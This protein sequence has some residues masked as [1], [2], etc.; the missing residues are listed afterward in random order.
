MN[1]DAN[2]TSRDANIDALI[3]H[4]IS[5][6]VDPDRHFLSGADTYARIYALANQ[7]QTVL[8]QQ[9]TTNRPVCMCSDN[10]ALVTAALLAAL[11][12]GPA[13]VLPYAYSKR[14]L[15]ETHQAIDFGV[16]LVD[17]ARPLPQGVT[18]I[19]L[20]TIEAAPATEM[21]K[22]PRTQNDEWIYLFTGGST[23]TPK[24]WT[25]TPCNL[26]A[27]A[28]NLVREFNVTDRD[29]ILATVPP[30]HIYG[31]LY[32]V[33]VPLLASAE[34]FPST[35]S[36][37]NEIIKLVAQADITIFVSIP[38]HYRALRDHRVERHNLRIAFSSAGALAPED[39]QAFFQSMAVSITEIYGST[40]TGGIAQRRRTAGQAALIPFSCIDWHIDDASLHVR[41]AFLS[42]ELETSDDGFFRTADRAQSDGSDG[43]SLLG[44][45]DGIV[46]VA[47][48]RV[49]LIKIQQI[50][51]QI[52]G[53]NDAY[54]YA[55]TIGQGRENEI[56][57]LVAGDVAA[58]SVRTI[59]QQRLEP[60]SQPRTI[61]IVEQMPLSSVGKYD[62]IE[63]ERLFA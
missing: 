30:N 13:L 62:R 18:A 55:K 10:R 57:A 33:L 29:K 48:K 54:V 9:E 37:P 23:G 51:Q 2:T 31:L 50:L 20:Q 11:N 28:Q 15:A 22:Q 59:V 26:L 4:L 19:D 16:A 7:I 39:D 58:E 60:Y 1:A 24:T 32:S 14:A 25:K 3:R 42:P 38:A 8:A 63:I 5:G 35:P 43:F 6:S 56:M 40:E 45:S 17:D 44:R 46:K 36:F 49:D 27:E 53:V 41:S 34:V 52:P 47:G 12:G 21:P 61:K